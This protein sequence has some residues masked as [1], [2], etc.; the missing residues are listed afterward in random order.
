MAAGASAPSA[1]DLDA[2]QALLGPAGMVRDP[3]QMQSYA[4]AARY[5]QGVAAAVLRPASTTE[6]SQA[7]AYCQRRGLRVI[8][9]SGNTGLVLGSTPDLSGAELVLSLDRMN[10][11]VAV[12]PADRSVI[13]EAG[14][15]LSSLNAALEASELWLPIDLAADPMVGGMVAT[16]TGGARFLRYGDMRA[17]L[18]GLEMVLGDRDG[19]VIA[20]GGLRK[21][22]ARLDL[23]RLVAGSCGAFGV[24]TRA[25]LA[26][27]PRARQ[28]AAAFLTPTTAER[29]IDVL[30]HLERHAGE[31]LSAFEG[32]SGAAMACALA[33]PNVRPPFVGAAPRFGLLVELATALPASALDLDRTLEAVLA[34]LFE[35][36]AAP[37]QDAV[38]A[39]P[40]ELWR[41][42]HALSEGLKSAGQVIGFDLAFRRD[43]TM[44]FRAEATARLALA[45]PD[46][47][48]CDFGHI[49]DGGLH[50]NL[51]SPRTLPAETVAA[52]RRLVLDLAV[53][54]Y[55]GSFSGEHGLGRINQD[56][57]DRYV[58][59]SE[60]RLAADVARAFGGDGLGAVRW[61]GA[62]EPETHII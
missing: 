20:L 51:V 21:D 9:Q 24:I 55:G 35:G 18:L 31:L 61:G 12:S 49:A 13:A 40:A 32:M 43:Q 59:P 60:R 3:G 54:G 52:I 45:A 16:N 48:V 26:V 27:H 36:D 4:V 6:V 23:G 11:I 42:R 50:F 5:G 37:L 33:V 38:I 30:L 56:A 58:P 47:R 17:H 19:T 34:P 62:A 25:T 14:V 7:L 15:R 44:G 46:V 28:S 41:F 1:A 39:P 57:Y 22:N 8:P 2:L 29:S 53:E 10:R